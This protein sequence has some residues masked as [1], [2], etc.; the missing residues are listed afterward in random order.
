MRASVG[1]R[2]IVRAAHIEEPSRDGEIIE[3][4]GPDG[5]PP[6][7]IR[8]SDNGHEGLYFPGPDSVVHHQGSGD[9]GPKPTP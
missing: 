8:W 1:D 6:Y 7:L 5:A 2:I 9:L 3:V 4:R